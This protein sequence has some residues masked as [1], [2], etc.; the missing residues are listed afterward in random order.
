MKKTLLFASILSWFNLIFW[1]GF[2]GLM[3]LGIMAMQAWPLMVAVFLLCSIPLNSYA[4][5]QLHRSIRR[6]S[7][8]LSHHTP[9]GV[10]FVGLVAMFF[11][12]YM[13][14]QAYAML[15]E[16]KEMLGIMKQSMSNVKL[17]DAQ[18]LGW[19]HVFG[20]SALVLGLLV[21]VSVILN[22]RLLRWYFFMHR[23]P[24]RP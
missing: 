4:A 21:V 16:P 10:R 11:G 3:L 24:D 8:K 22:T 14:V 13:L 20:I 19:L 7:V 6:P 5:I 23:P 12:I 9:A 15:E 1:I 18:L 17:T 2:L